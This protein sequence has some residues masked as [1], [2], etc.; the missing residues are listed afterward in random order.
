MIRKN[1]IGQ[2]SDF[3]IHKLLPP[4]DAIQVDT[5]FQE[6]RK[7]FSRRDITYTGSEAKPITVEW[8]AENYLNKSVLLDLG[9]NFY[10]NIKTDKGIRI[11]VITDLSAS[12]YDEGDTVADSTGTILAD[13]PHPKRIQVGLKV[14]TRLD[15]QSPQFQQM[16]FST[17]ENAVA[18]AAEKMLIDNLVADAGINV[19]ANG[20]FGHEKLNDME[21]AVLIDNENQSAL[22]YIA[23]P[24]N[25]KLIKQL[26]AAGGELLYRRGYLNSELC[27]FTSNC[28]ENTLIFGDWKQAHVYEFD[29]VTII[30]D[31]YTDIKAGWY[32]FTIIGF[33]SA[34]YTDPASFSK[35]ADITAS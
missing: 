20:S 8:F 9:A 26:E 24:N 18:S 11:P 32:Y 13:D 29:P 7:K 1:E 2:F 16:I 17:M 15:L 30:K 34:Q 10:P 27:K 21:Q 23:N 33:W 4:G 14:S 3:D 28:P 22:G 31:P 19:V 5:T 12:Y 6:I 35:I 25:R